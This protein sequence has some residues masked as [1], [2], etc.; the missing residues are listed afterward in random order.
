MWGCYCLSVVRKTEVRQTSEDGSKQVKMGEM[1]GERDLATL[2]R[3]SNHQGYGS[4]GL[5][6]PP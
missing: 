6:S 1:E 3:S 2:S 4:L 5:F